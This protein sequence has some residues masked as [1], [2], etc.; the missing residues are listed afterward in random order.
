MI[1]FCEIYF[2]ILTSIQINW[3]TYIILSSDI[4]VVMW[5]TCKLYVCIAKFTNIIYVVNLNY[6]KY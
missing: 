5:P 4:L 2:Y 3:L 6:S 1:E